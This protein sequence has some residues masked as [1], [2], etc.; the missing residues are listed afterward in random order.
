M[1][2]VLFVNPLRTSETI[3]GETPEG[4]PIFFG[5]CILAPRS[6]GL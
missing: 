1:N 6:H 5:R 2:A 3:F 4:I